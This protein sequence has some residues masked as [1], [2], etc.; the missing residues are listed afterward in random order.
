MSTEL[1]SIPTDPRAPPENNPRFRQRRPPRRASRRVRTRN[2]LNKVRYPASDTG[3]APAVEQSSGP[4]PTDVYTYMSKEAQSAYSRCFPEAKYFFRNTKNAHPHAFSAQARRLGEKKAMKQ[5]DRHITPQHPLID[6]GFGQRLKSGKWAS[7]VH[8]CENG[9]DPYTLHKLRLLEFS[10]PASRL[11]D[12]QKHD[13]ETKRWTYCTCSAKEC[14]HCEPGAALFCHSIYYNTPQDVADILANTRSKF[15]ISIHHLFDE[16]SGS[17]YGYDGRFESV[18]TNRDGTIK[19]SVAGND[20]VYEHSD[21]RWLRSPQAFHPV[22]VNGEPYYLTFSH[23]NVD[24]FGDTKICTLALVKAPKK[25]TKLTPVK[26]LVGTVSDEEI[27][28]AL[29]VKYKDHRVFQSDKVISLIRG[30][31]EIVIPKKYVSELRKWAAMRPFSDKTKTGLVAEARRLIKPSLYLPL[32]VSVDSLTSVMPIIVCTVMQTSIEDM[33]NVTSFFTTKNQKMIE[34]YN[35]KVKFEYWITPGKLP[36]LSIVI[37][38]LLMLLLYY[39]VLGTSTVLVAVATLVLY[40]SVPPLVALY[41]FLDRVLGHE[42]V[43]W[44]DFYPDDEQATGYDKWIV[45]ACLAIVIL[46]AFWRALKRTRKKCYDFWDQFKMNV[47]TSRQCISG[48]G[49]VREV[50]AIRSMRSW[51]D[52]SNFTFAEDAKLKILADLSSVDRRGP[53]VVAVA[54]CFTS[55]A[56]LVHSACQVTL[57]QAMRCRVLIPLPRVDHDS[58]HAWNVLDKQMEDE[59]DLYDA[60]GYVLS[61]KSPADTVPYDWE[62]YLARYPPAK[63]KVLINYRK[64]VFNGEITAR[65]AT[66]SCFVKREKIMAITKGNFVPMKPRVIQGGPQKEKVTSGPW[67]L[68]YSQALKKCLHMKNWIWFCSGARTE[69]YNSWFEYQTSRLGGVSRCYFSG[70]DF[71]TYDV[72]QGKLAIER[73]C[74]HLESLG[75]KK[76]VIDADELLNGKRQTRVYGN[77]LKA[78][79]TYRRKSGEN[80]TSAGNSKNTADTVASFWKEKASAVRCTT[81]KSVPDVRDHV[82]IAVIGDDNFTIFTCFILVLLFGTIDVFVRELTLHAEALGF[83]LKIQ[84]ND[85]PVSVEFIS[86][87]FYRVGHSFCIGKKPGRTLVKLG[88]MMWHPHMKQKHYLPL[89]YGTVISYL[90]T[91]L[92]VPFLRVYLRAILKYLKA[93][94]IRPKFDKKV[95]FRLSGD[96]VDGEVDFSLFE[97]TYGLGKTSEAEFSCLLE[98]AICKYGLPCIVDS[99]HVDRLLAVDTEF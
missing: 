88:Y 83:K 96:K 86:C 10:D 13:A 51:I 79:Y 41:P 20:L 92:H 3:S 78:E 84:V 81:T 25:R 58:I 45:I 39:D 55:A 32:K 74:R 61:R 65:R 43:T 52:L 36:L 8:G 93:L 54:V 35:K 26:R 80:L 98:K 64:K 60:G 70:T 40:K 97:N 4:R 33:E 49:S 48:S 71:S 24:N 68:N 34:L 31:K 59:Y 82:A 46:L 95:Q 77:A 66:Y 90:P 76:H 87:R 42:T 19:M 15:G 69:D 57:I 56:P 27:L 14:N 18:Y 12:G 28:T 44:R 23:K 53:A 38:M 85:N 47:E 72:T 22:Q 50:D 6:V 89:L 99:P 67:I 91:G 29:R 7:K 5:L 75:L 94:G 1:I 11:G 21:S 17:F 37:L 2:T 9:D 30:D 63:R 16:G 73:E 62:S